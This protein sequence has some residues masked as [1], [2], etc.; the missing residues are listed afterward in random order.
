MSWVEMG[1]SWSGQVVKAKL[2]CDWVSRGIGK[3]S[4]RSRTEK[5]ELSEG[6]MEREVYC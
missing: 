5:W 1:V 6:I 3:V 2:F 4:L